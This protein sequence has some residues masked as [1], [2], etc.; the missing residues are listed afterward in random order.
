MKGNYN[1]QPTK[2]A[3]VKIEVEDAEGKVS[4]AEFTPTSGEG[5][6]FG[7]AFNSQD[8]YPPDIHD[9]LKIVS[10]ANYMV[11]FQLEFIHYDGITMRVTP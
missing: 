4:T 10:T 9:T 6:L 3:R 11:G 7:C 5:M 8:I 1:Q 2:V